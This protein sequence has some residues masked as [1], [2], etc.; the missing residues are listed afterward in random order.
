MD[1]PP[2]DDE[3]RK[4]LNLPKETPVIRGS[5]ASVR[6]R[7]L[8]KTGLRIFE[9]FGGKAWMLK[10]MA[11]LVIGV[12]VV[13]PLAVNFVE[14][15]TNFWKPKLVVM[16]DVAEPYL[17]TANAFGAQ[18]TDDWVA[19]LHAGESLPPDPHSPI[20]N[21]SFILA[22]DTAHAYRFPNRIKTP[23]IIHFASD[24]LLHAGHISRLPNIGESYHF[25]P[26]LTANRYLSKGTRAVFFM[27]DTLSLFAETSTHQSLPRLNLGITRS[28]FSGPAE[29]IPPT[30]ID[31]LD[32]SELRRLG[33]QWITQRRT[34]ALIVPTQFDPT[35]SYV[36]LNEGFPETDEIQ[37]LARWQLPFA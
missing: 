15:I 4:A 1:L 8:H 30:A 33:D 13:P 9:L 12:V 18:F 24:W 35:R 37:V 28:H 34:P 10:S 5:L 14:T 27:C 21:N 6:K 16:H 29:V 11:G 3:I 36:I 7:F 26:L 22:P 17:Q 23:E 32:N 31:Q 19:F 2:S 20:G 25:P